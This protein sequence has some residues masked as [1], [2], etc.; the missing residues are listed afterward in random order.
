MVFFNDITNNT[1]TSHSGIHINP[2]ADS[3]GVMASFNNI[4]GNSPS[5]NTYGVYNGGA[6]NLNARYNWWGHASGPGGEGPGTGDTI[7]ENVNYRPWLPKPFEDVVVGMGGKYISDGPNENIKPRLADLDNW[8]LEIPEN[9]VIENMYSSE[10]GWLA[11]TML[12]NLEDLGGAPTPANLAA[13][14]FIDITTIP[15]NIAE[16]IRIT[17][18]YTDEDVEGIEEG[19]LELYHWSY[20]D[21]TWHDVTITT[22]PGANTITGYVDR[23]SPFGMFGEE[24]E[25][26][27]PEEE[28][29]PGPIPEVEVSISPSSR[30]G[31]PGAELTYTVTVT[32]NGGAADTY[33]LEI[34]GGTGWAPTLDDYSLSIG[35]GGSKTTTLRVTVP[36][37]ASDGDSTTITVTATSQ[38]DPEVSDSGTCTARAVAPVPGVSVSISPTLRLGSPGESL[39][40]TV[41]VTNM[42]T[43]TDSYTLGKSDTAGWSLSL[44]SSVGPL[45]PGE[46]TTATLEVTIP[47]GVGDGDSTMVTVTATSQADP[48]VYDSDTCTVTAEVEE[49]APLWPYIGI[50]ILIIIIL[51]II[52]AARRR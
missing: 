4:V 20:E 19:S 30:E 49:E 2:G 16:N 33:D 25:E 27:V 35:A 52:G 41:T 14:M 45:N 31:A 40:F 46:S 32:N 36:S 12:G 7:S 24:V 50:I 22:N 9:V 3:T 43:I 48:S 10:N 17:V 8:M 34:S 47:S 38:T 6:D 18:Q 28:E 13:A 15:E 21:E 23:L 26:N 39:A 37:G 11:I 42:G 44:A 1:G 5:E 51:A 29:P